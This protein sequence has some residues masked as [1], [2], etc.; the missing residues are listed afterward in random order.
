VIFLANTDRAKALF[1]LNQ[2]ALD[3]NAIVFVALAVAGVSLNWS[4]GL[5]RSAAF[6]ST[7]KPGPS[8]RMNA[9]GIRQTP[10]ATLATQ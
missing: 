3:F 5:L 1:K 10:S 2:S 8:G 6:G 4:G 7:A 9:D